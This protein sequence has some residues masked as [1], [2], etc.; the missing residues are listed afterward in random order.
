MAGA[1]MLLSCYKNDGVLEGGIDEA[2]RGCF[3]GPM[4]A[5]AVIW[6][7]E[8]TWSEDLRKISATIKDSK[9]VAPKRRGVLEAAIKSNAVAWAIGR[10]EAEEID[11]IGMTA[12]NRL[13]FLRAFEGLS[14]KP[15][16]LLIDGC[17]YMKDIDGVEQI[18]ET[19]ADGVYISVAAASIL[20][21]EAHD[22]IV[23]DCVVADSALQENYSIGSSKGYGTSSHCAGLL[24]HGVYAGHRRLFLRNLL[25]AAIYNRPDSGSCLID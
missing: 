9:K 8:S 3:W 10:V 23:M 4:I 21:K 1:Q 12:A 13:A 16:R 22:R 20:A 18:V 24:K 2:G 17:L 14:V 19:K 5:A 11:A 6:P 7:E 25:G 15:G